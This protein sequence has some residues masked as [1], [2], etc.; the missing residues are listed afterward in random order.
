MFIQ[1]N[2]IRWWG[3]WTSSFLCPGLTSV[4]MYNHAPCPHHNGICWSF[5]IPTWF[6]D[7]HPYTALC[8]NFLSSWPWISSTS[9]CFL[10]LSQAS[11]YQ[12]QKEF[13]LLS[14]ATQGPHETCCGFLAFSP[15]SAAKR[16][17]SPLAPV[18]LGLLGNPK[19]IFSIVLERIRV[20]T[21]FI[22]GSPNCLVV[23]VNT[24]FIFTDLRA[25]KTVH[26]TS[27]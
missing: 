1:C 18:L 26:K 27:P 12:R 20:N 13:L 3:I 24:P 6:L 4:A 15:S 23:S 7:T 11:C 2:N 21:S 25:E 5:S 22:H 17:L 19:R 8:Y 9:A 14:P 16:H 10:S